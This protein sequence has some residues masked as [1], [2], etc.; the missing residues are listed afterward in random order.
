[1]KEE[2]VVER[3]GRRSGEEEETTD[4]PIKFILSSTRVELAKYLLSA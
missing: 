4:I 2:K 3:K 1:M